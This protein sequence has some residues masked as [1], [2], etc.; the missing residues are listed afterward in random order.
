LLKGL[1]LAY[2]RDLQEDKPAVFA[3]VDSALDSMRAARLLVSHL[4]F[5]RARLASAAADPGLLATD[6]AEDLVRGGIPFRDAHHQVGRAYRDGKLEPPWSGATSLLKRNLP[7]GPHPRR[8]ASR[9]SAVR[10]RAAA[11]RRWSQAHPPALPQ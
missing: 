1:P 6:A 10:R 3:A 8:V 5:D 7:G 4:E 9:S 2:D 11:L